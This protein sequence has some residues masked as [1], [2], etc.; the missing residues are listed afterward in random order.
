MRR[1]LPAALIFLTLGP[2]PGTHH[3]Y[4]VVDRSQSAS[5]RPLI[6][7]A[8]T[9]GSLRFV[10]GWRLTSPNSF[11]GGFSA[12]ARL[13]PGRFLLLGDN[14]R[15][16]RLTLGAGGV[17]AVT[18]GALP[19]P[20]RNPGSKAFTDTEAVAVDPATGRIWVALEGIDQIWRLD[21]ALTRIESRNKSAQL[22]HWPANRGAEAMARLAD[23]RMI[24]FSEDADDDDRGREALL[25]T[26][27][28]ASP[29]AR[30]LRFFY[31]AGGKGQVSD[32]APL[33]DGRILL[34]HRSLGVS[35]LFTTTLAIVDPADITKDGVVRSL[36]V[37]TVP[38]ALRENYEG[39]AVS[40]EGGRTFLW[41]V[42]DDN[43]NSWQRSLLLQFE[44]VDLPGSKKAAR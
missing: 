29:G 3:R 17:E 35:P 15:A 9:S 13:G 43:F 8:G 5:A 41:L 33:P 12:L 36:I 11:F 23:G 25:F 4:T 21:P 1:L 24:V 31:D 27:D 26:G 42:A 18:I 39:A 7:P 34:V 20:L 28:P 32:A 44:L 6:H 10:R 16:V 2:V 19:L 37:G 40:V 38:E 30:G 14:G 22:A